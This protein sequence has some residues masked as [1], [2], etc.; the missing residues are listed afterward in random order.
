[1]QEWSGLRSA[2]VLHGVYPHQYQYRYRGKG[3][4]AA[5]AAGAAPVAAPARPYRDYFRALAIGVASVRWAPTAHGCVRCDYLATLYVSEGLNNQHTHNSVLLDD[6]GPHAWTA[7]ICVCRRGAWAVERRC[8]S[9][10]PLD[11]GTLARGRSGTWSR[12]LDERTTA[13]IECG[14]LTLGTSRLSL[15]ARTSPRLPL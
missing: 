1:M 12:P 9:N 6:H 15:F 10:S 2:A 13:N 8:S 4:S 3:D 14:Q 7:A 5:G 11:L